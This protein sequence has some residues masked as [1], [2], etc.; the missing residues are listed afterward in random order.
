MSKS[1]PIFALR[2]L[3]TSVRLWSVLLLPQMPALWTARTSVHFVAS[4]ILSPPILFY[5]LQ[6]SSEYMERW[7]LRLLEEFFPSPEE[8]DSK[9]G[10]G[11][12]KLRDSP[13]TVI[14]K[15]LSSTYEHVIGEVQYHWSEGK[16]LLFDMAELV[17]SSIKDVNIKLLPK[18]TSSDALNDK[19]PSYSDSASQRQ[20]NSTRLGEDQNMP[21]EPDTA[22]PLFAL[23]ERAMEAE[24]EPSPLADNQIESQINAIF[25]A[26]DDTTSLPST[27]DPTQQDSKRSE[28]NKPVRANNARSHA[29]MIIEKYRTSSL[30]THAADT[31]RHHIQCVA[32]GF[33]FIPLESMYARS[34]VNAYLGYLASRFRVHA[35][36][37][38]PPGSWCGAGSLLL[39]GVYMR[40]L[41]LCTGAEVAVSYGVWQ[42]ST[43]IAWWIGKKW[44]RWGHF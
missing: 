25:E 40:N 1:P 37:V 20:G 28:S 38:Y 34:L 18:N 17:G 33:L 8:R 22:P 36:L 19:S 35:P 4:L 9:A 10:L 41:L 3:R 42:A 31:L 29:D 43:G 27:F 16:N 23:E 24:V 44:F 11:L 5:L 14:T 26:F 21:S 32:R 15:Y 13:A 39:R 7:S 30:S 2:P 6:C 12:S